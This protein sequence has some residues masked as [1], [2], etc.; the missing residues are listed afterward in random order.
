MAR[1]F[2]PK[3]AV[4]TTANAFAETGK[5]LFDTMPE[6][7]EWPYPFVV[8]MALSIELYLKSYLAEDDLIP[9]LVHDD[10]SATYQG[11]TKCLTREHKFDVLY[12]KIP[13]HIK[14]KIE[15]EFPSSILGKSFP[16]FESALAKFANSFI[17]ARYP[18]EKGGFKGGCISDLMNISTFLRKTIYKLGEFR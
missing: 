12:S 9:F 15:E 1:D 8:N 18:Y 16:S 14:S 2:L 7:I 10:G 11:F 5:I 4:V 17:E 6:G 3:M 13:T